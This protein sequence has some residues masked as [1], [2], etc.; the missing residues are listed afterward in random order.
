MAAAKKQRFLCFLYWTESS[1]IIIQSP[2]FTNDYKFY[3]GVNEY[4]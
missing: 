1:S 2:G 4:Q 3:I